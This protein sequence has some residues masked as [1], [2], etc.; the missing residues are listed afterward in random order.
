M[1]KA[2]FIYCLYFS[3]AELPA[4]LIYIVPKQNLPSLNL[5]EMPARRY[6]C[7]EAEPYVGAFSLTALSTHHQWALFG[8][9]G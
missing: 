5:V 3:A 1:Q 8:A 7:N 9:Y 4:S 2:N 6:D